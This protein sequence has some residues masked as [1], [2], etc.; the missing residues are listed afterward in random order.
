MLCSYKC[1]NFA[2]KLRVLHFFTSLSLFSPAV[3]SSLPTSVSFL[4][5]SGVQKSLGIIRM[6]AIKGKA[7]WLKKC[8][9]DIS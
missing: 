2:I 6:L 3:Q 5:S 9:T 8:S 7:A 1:F 4:D